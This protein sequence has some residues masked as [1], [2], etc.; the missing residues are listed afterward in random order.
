[1]VPASGCGDQSAHFLYA[2]QFNLHRSGPNPLLSSCRPKSFHNPL[3][4]FPF[5]GEYK[6]ERKGD[7]TSDQHSWFFHTFNLGA[8][9]FKVCPLKIRLISVSMPPF[10]KYL[11]TA[12][13]WMNASSGTGR[14]HMWRARSPPVHLPRLHSHTH[15]WVPVPCTVTNDEGWQ[16]RVLA[17]RELAT[18]FRESFAL[19]QV[20]N[21]STPP[22]SVA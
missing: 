9:Y 7:E 18:G 6:W 3:Q 11:T 21:A 5:G 19:A 1:M 20:V 22:S 12:C 13:I 8:R 10:I 15:V 14:L 17:G 4:A 2:A 16:G